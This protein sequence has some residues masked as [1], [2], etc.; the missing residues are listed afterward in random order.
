MQDQVPLPRALDV[1][2]FAAAR[3]QE[4]SLPACRAIMTLSDCLFICQL[5]H[6]LQIRALQAAIKGSEHADKYGVTALPRHLR[7]RTR[8]H[9]PYK[10]SKRPNAKRQRTGSEQQQQQQQQQPQQQA[11][12]QQPSAEPPPAQSAVRDDQV[13]HCA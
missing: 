8:S 6:L 11:Q 4:A 3:E 1:Q 10:H 2:K 9:K 5:E 13:K 7:R 12:Q